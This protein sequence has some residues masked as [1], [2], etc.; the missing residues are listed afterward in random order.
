MSTEE[1][2]LSVKNSIQKKSVTK[3]DVTESIKEYLGEENYK[4]LK[5][6]TLDEYNELISFNISPVKSYFVKGVAPKLKKFQAYFIA[7]CSQK[8]YSYSTFMMKDYVTGLAERNDDLTFLMGADKELLFLYLHGETS[9]IGNTDAWLGY[10]ALDK[11]ANRNR[12]G[13]V[14]VV[15]SERDFPLFE[16]SSELEK[17]NLGG[18]VTAKTVEAAV[19]KVKEAVVSKDFDPFV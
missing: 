1:E 18:A 5:S 13:L 19:N 11:I 2:I 17:I 3:E 9:G 8:R 4:V 15:L 7:V 16:G 10:S 6:I 12:K 14:T